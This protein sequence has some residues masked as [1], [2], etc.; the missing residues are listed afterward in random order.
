MA[1]SAARNLQYDYQ[2]LSNLVITADKNLI[3]R[4]SRDEPTGEVLTLA[5]KVRIQEMG[6]KAMRSKPPMLAEK[7]AKYFKYKLYFLLGVKN[8]TKNISKI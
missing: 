3:E 8:V 2:I 1:E 5:G 7:K 6:S 4:R